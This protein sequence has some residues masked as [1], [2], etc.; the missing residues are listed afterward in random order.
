MALACKSIHYN[1]PFT[2][3]GRKIDP[4]SSP[5]P[6]DF[7]PFLVKDY[8]CSKFRGKSKYGEENIW[9]V[10]QHFRQELLVLRFFFIVC[11]GQHA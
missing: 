7:E 2:F 3:E 5:F 8:S 4:P 6:F 9:H 11:H 10:S 1:N